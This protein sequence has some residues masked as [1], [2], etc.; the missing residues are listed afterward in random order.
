MARERI[1]T[2]HMSYYKERL[3]PQQPECPYGQ[4]GKKQLY[5]G[6]GIVHESNDFARV[7]R[8]CLNESD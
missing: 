8:V 5:S 2:W 7:E 6:G 4:T 1:A 3:F